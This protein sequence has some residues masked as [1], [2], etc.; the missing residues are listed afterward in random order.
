M[1]EGKIWFDDA[2]FRLNVDGRGNFLG[3]F[4]GDD[5]ILVI[6]KNGLFQ[7]IPDLIFQTILRIIFLLLK[8]SDPGKFIQ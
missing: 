3:E 4:S 1:G 8:N 6:T 2:V 5:K 7:D